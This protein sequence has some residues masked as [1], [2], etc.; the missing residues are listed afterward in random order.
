MEALMLLIQIF[1]LDQYNFLNNDTSSVG[2]V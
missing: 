1:Y 2:N